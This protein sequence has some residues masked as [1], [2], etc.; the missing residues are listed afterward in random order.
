MTYEVH[1]KLKWAL[2]FPPTVYF[3]TLGGSIGSD[4]GITA[5]AQY[6]DV[7]TSLKT[8]T[9]QFVPLFIKAAFVAIW[10]TI[11]AHVLVGKKKIET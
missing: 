9:S 4:S 3:I 10:P 11:A 7:Q 5:W 1:Q 8:L 2:T 6:M